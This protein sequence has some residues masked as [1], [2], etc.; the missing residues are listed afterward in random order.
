MDVRE[1]FSTEGPLAKKFPGYAPREQQIELS[2]KIAEAIDQEIPLIGEAPTGVGK[3][4]AA[5]VPAF[6]AI[7]KYDAPILVVTSSILLQEQYFNKDVPFLEE[8]FGMKTNATLIKGK[9]NY[10]CLQKAIEKVGA[11]NSRQAAE[12]EVIQQWAAT[13]K[14]GDVSELNFVPSRPVWQDFAIMD[15]H[16]CAGRDCPMFDQCF[17]YNKRR[18]MKASKLIICNYHYFFTAMNEE[19]MLPPGIKAVIMDEGHEISSIARDMQEKTFNTF[20]YQRMNQMLAKA[21]KRMGEQVGIADEIELTEML[22]SHQAFMIEAAQYFKDYKP[23]NIEK[24]TLPPRERKDFQEMA[25][26]HLNKLRQTANLLEEHLTVNGL[27]PNM[28]HEWENYYTPELIQWQLAQERY[29]GALDTQI[30]IAKKMFT[31]TEG[32][33]DTFIVWME[34]FGETGVAFKMKP[35]TSAPMTAGIFSEDWTK[36]P[37]RLADATPIVISATLS[38]HGLFKHIRNDLGIDR[39]TLEVR[40]KTPFDLTENMLW[41]LPKTA[42]PGND[43]GHLPSVLEEMEKIIRT[44]EGR[45]LCLFTSNKA[46]QAAGHHLRKMLPKHIEVVVQNEIPKQMI[47]DRLKE[48]PHTVI[49]AT[50]SFFTGVDIQGQNLSAVLLDKLPFPMSGDP[51]ND[52]LISEDHGFFKY[53]LPETII[54]MKQAFGRL[55]RTMADKGV[56]AVFDGRLAAARYKSIIFESFDFKLNTTRDFERVRTYLEEIKHG[57]DSGV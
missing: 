54:S 38:V 42:V 7:K 44:L 39:E 23:K 21:Q 36:R 40:V 12:V 51:V 26:P 19:K 29:L 27:N 47:I 13:T 3:S 10:V 50:R 15:E 45:T 2:E 14:N 55:N 35:F 9:G 11:T 49:L 6:Q 18:Q 30:S 16:E 46:V 56:V 48:N 41:Y 57:E 33:E 8:L 20:A 53:S 4:F 25:E 24:W 31:Y 37:L 1:F 28:R 17:Y 22:Q 5:L 52:Y 32:V 34:T 43:P